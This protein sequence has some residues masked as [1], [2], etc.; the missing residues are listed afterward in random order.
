MFADGLLATHNGTGRDNPM[1]ARAIAGLPRAGTTVMAAILSQHPDANVSLD[2]RDDAIWKNRSAMNSENFLLSRAL[3]GSFPRVVCP[4]RPIVEILASYLQ[5]MRKNSMLSLM[6]LDARQRGY[7]SD[8]VGICEY[9]TSEHGNVG[10]S[11]ASLKIAKRDFADHILIVDNSKFSRNPISTMREVEDFFDLSEC[12]YDLDN[13]VNPVSED[14]LRKYALSGLHDIGSK[15]TSQP[16][17]ASE[18]LGD[19]IYERYSSPKWSIQ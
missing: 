6:E 15:F 13:L 3:T 7:S 11:L 2:K 14:D 4:V 19:A 18:I 16:I 12:S 10:A 9:L 1:P 5:L 8:D 17:N